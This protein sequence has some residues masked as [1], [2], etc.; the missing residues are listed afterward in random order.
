MKDWISAARPRTLP[1]AVS[2]ILVGSALAYAFGTFRMPVLVL[3]LCTAMLLQVLSNLA[4]DL[5]DHL[6]GADGDGRI[7]P[8]RSVQSGAISPGAMKRAVAIFGVLSFL[9]GILLITY[10]L[11]ISWTTLLF[12]FMGLAAIGAAVRYTYG[13]NP[14]GYSGMGDPSVFMFFGIVAV[15]GTFFLHTQRIAT[16]ALLPAIGFGLLSTGVLN[17]NNMRDLRHDEANG[18]RTLAV[19]LGMAN[20]K[21]YHGFLIIGG[22]GCLVAFTA[23]NF[24]GMPQWA[25]LITTPALAAHL[26]AVIRNHDPALLDPQLKRLAMGTFLTAVAFSLGLLLV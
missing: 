15:V 17:V 25:F 11:G 1:L 14:Y 16:P 12:L 20:A 4:N 19:V 23:V 7:G 2:S 9:S 3:A 8:A 26:R 22:L 5:G 18:K 21:G 10:A 6:N 13:R 24:K